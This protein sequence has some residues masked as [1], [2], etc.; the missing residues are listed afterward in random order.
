MKNRVSTI[1]QFDNVDFVG[2]VQCHLIIVNRKDECVH[3]STVIEG[4]E[5]RGRY[6]VII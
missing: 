4:I 6:V 5:C 1:A 3:I 2:H